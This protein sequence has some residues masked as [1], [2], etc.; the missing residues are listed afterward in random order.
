MKKDIDSLWVWVAYF[1]AIMLLMLTF[2]ILGW[3]SAE[4]HKIIVGGMP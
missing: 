1:G 3:E 2:K 4:P